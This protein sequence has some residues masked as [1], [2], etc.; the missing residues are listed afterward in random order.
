MCILIMRILNNVRSSEEI[1]VQVPS[2]QEYVN[3]KLLLVFKIFEATCIR[4]WFVAISA[5]EKILQLNTKSKG[6][7]KDKEMFKY[8]LFSLLTGA[9]FF[10]S[11]FYWP[12]FE[13][14]YAVQLLMKLAIS[15]L[16]KNTINQL[17]FSEHKLYGFP[18]SDS[19]KWIQ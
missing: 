12:R 15:L 5:L 7:E 6:K 3:T 18:Q 17:F 10:P 11:S 13:S 16:L 2:L 9:V 4:I 14:P 1:S 19:S 8:S